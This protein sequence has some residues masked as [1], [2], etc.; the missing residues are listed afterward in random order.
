MELV[1][2]NRT[3]L[4]VKDYG[5]FGS[6]YEIVLD[7]VVYQKSKFTI[8][9]PN[10]NA[11]VGDIVFTRGL[12][13]YYIGIIET[14]SK[15]DEDLK[16]S[17]EV[18]DFSSIFDIQVTVSSYTGDLCEF[19]R[20]LIY[21]TFINNSDKYQVLPYLNLTKS[22]AINGSLTYEGTELV[23]ITEVSEML[24]KRYGIRYK[25][26]L[27]I[28]HEGIIKGINVEITGVTK[29]M[30]I[31][32]DLQCIKDLEIVDSNKQGSNKIIFYP[33][34]DNV[35]YKSTITYYLLT[36]G[37]ITTSSTHSK[38]I[39]NVK[40]MSQF[41]SDNEYSSLYTKA[42]SELLKSNLEHNI[43]FKI[44][45]DNLVLVPFENINVG[46]FL[47][48]VTEKKTYSTMVTQLSVKGNLYECSV[49]LGEYRIKLTDKIK[50]LEK[51]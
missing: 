7:A 2:L 39:K 21:K 43:E 29:G 45:V 17:L 47:E 8:N 3:N 32:H 25:C 46:D 26:S 4:E 28:D 23:S 38:R 1:I 10:L 41:Y 50:L 9:K 20:L 19:L 27:N 5:Y 37:T 22:C 42:T 11:E 49:V 48:F 16:V 24:A 31:R 36:D 40:C 12:P 44:S 33:N 15:E 34:D 14:I 18:N 6:D 35:T 30:K 51:K 13:F